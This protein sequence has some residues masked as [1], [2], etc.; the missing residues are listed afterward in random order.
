MTVKKL[1]KSPKDVVPPFVERDIHRKVILC[2]LAQP[3]RRYISLA[4]KVPNYVA[5]CAIRE[6]ANDDVI[7]TRRHVLAVYNGH[8]RDS[9]YE[10]YKSKQR[11]LIESVTSIFDTYSA[12]NG[13]VTIYVCDDAQEANDILRQFRAGKL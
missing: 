2:M 12:L 3:Q 9:T 7:E 13:P 6:G 8:I 4:I 5:F 1:T 10:W 11:S